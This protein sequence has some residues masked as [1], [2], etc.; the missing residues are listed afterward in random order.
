MRML[1]CSHNV[2]LYLVLKMIL[3]NLIKSYFNVHWHASTFFIWYE[4]AV[5][6]EVI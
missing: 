6:F 3:Q 1:L 2:L 4:A 5:H